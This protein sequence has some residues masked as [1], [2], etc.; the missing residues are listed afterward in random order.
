MLLEGLVERYRENVQT[1]HI[2][3]IAD[4]T[5]QDC[6]QLE[7][8]MIK[9]SKWLPGHDQAGAENEDVP[10]PEELKADIEALENWVTG[11]RQRRKS[12]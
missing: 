6:E 3:K 9:C 11:I 5:I 10:E 2:R 8:G 4:I 7:A 12:G 1:Q